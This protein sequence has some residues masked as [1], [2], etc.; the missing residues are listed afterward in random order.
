MWEIKFFKGFL[1]EL[2]QRVLFNENQILFTCAE[3]KWHKNT[4]NLESHMIMAVDVLI[5][6]NGDLADTFVLYK[7]KKQMGFLKLE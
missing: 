6:I 7:E 1:R 3:P 2:F 5:T 4:K